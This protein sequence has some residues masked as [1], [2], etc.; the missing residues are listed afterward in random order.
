MRNA[1]VRAEEIDSAPSRLHA[2]REAVRDAQGYL[3]QVEST[4]P[5]AV[6]EL[7]ARAVDEAD[8]AVQLWETQAGGGDSTD[9]TAESRRL[10]GQSK[11]LASDFRDAVLNELE[12]VKSSAGPED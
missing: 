12:R 9:W 4:F 8:R 3:T 11:R 2:A 7:G 5:A 10:V 1:I 6:S